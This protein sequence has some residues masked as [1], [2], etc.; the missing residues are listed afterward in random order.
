MRVT[1]DKIFA[2]AI[3]GLQTEAMQLT[4]ERQGPIKELCS[5]RDCLKKLTEKADIKEDVTQRYGNSM[6]LFA[7]TNTKTC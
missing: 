7:E 5:R 6:Q 4:A 3:K 1:A 2:T